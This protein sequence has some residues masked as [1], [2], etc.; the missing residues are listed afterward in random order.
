MPIHCIWL[1]GKF[2]FA[3]NNRP[4]M[5]NSRSLRVSIFTTWDIGILNYIHSQIKSWG[6]NIIR[7]LLAAI[8]DGDRGEPVFLEPQ[9]KYFSNKLH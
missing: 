9:T 2:Y 5:S 1:P 4:I 6:E 3:K 8:N 7:H